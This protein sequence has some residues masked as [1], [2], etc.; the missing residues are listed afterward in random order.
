MS[1]DPKSR[2]G[3]RTLSAPDWLMA[4][5]SD[6]LAARG[7]TGAD[8]D[9]PVF[10]TSDGKQLHYSNWRQRVWLP[11]TEAAGIPGLRFHDL[12]HTAGTAMVASGVDVKTAQ[13]RL[14][15]RPGTFARF[16]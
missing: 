13:V 2:A 1:Q 3:R 12:K 6:H 7:L 10:T 9:A 4:M 8:P 11:A 16:K 15:P 14:V 5:V